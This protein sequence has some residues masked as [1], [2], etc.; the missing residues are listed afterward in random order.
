MHMY[1]LSSTALL[2]VHSDAATILR[3]NPGA[4]DWFALIFE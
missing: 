3:P 4:I 1:G 2:L